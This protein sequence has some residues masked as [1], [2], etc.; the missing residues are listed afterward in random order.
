MEMNATQ[1]TKLNNGS[2]KAI[3]DMLH[4]IL[5]Q[6]EASDRYNQIPGEE[7]SDEPCEYFKDLIEN[8]R[9]KLTSDYLGKSDSEEHQKLDRIIGET[10]EFVTSYEM[11]GVVTRWRE[12]NPR[13]NH[14]DCAF[15]LIEE[16]GMETAEELYRKG[17]LEFLPSEEDIEARK[18][19]F[20]R[21]ERAD[22][23]G[24]YQEELLKTLEMVFESE[25]G[26]A[27]V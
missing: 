26:G 8:A 21:V 27:N 5:A 3:F 9:K 1:N 15:E 10:E 13:L 14:F 11:P 12:I 17:M 2:V 7:D 4:D 22:D 16:V 19:Y 18:E 25:F 24:V 6:Y 23:A 20:G